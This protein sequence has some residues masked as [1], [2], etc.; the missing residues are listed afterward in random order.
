MKRLSTAFAFLA[1]IALASCVSKPAPRPETAPAAPQAKERTETYRT[2]LVTKE[3]RSFSDG[4][5][6]RISS[7]Q[8][9]ETLEDRKSV[10]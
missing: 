6:D 9:S 7:Y 4:L 8:W 5:V 1:A 2:A 10:V 3:T